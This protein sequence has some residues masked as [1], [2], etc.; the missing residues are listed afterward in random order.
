MEL[1][2]RGQ[3]IV[4]TGHQLSEVAKRAK[5][6]DVQAS[7]ELLIL[8]SHVSSDPHLAAAVRSTILEKIRSL[9]IRTNSLGEEYLRRSALFKRLVDLEDKMESGGT[10][11]RKEKTFLRKTRKR[12]RWI[13]KLETNG[14]RFIPPVF[15]PKN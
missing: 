9:D 7:F 5:S 8:V 10:L 2:D 11:T 15:P 4:N 12:I 13:E 6:G 3:Q 14:S 1:F